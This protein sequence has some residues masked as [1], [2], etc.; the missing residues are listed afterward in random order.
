MI[1]SSNT[2]QVVKNVAVISLAIGCPP[3]LCP[4]DLLGYYQQISSAS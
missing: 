1:Y 3:V 4:F 2:F